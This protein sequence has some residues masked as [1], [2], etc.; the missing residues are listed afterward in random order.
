M[1]AA[2]S[3]ETTDRI[4]IDARMADGSVDVVNTGTIDGDVLLT[5]G[6]DR[7]NSD[8]GSQTSGV[9][10]GGHGNDTIAGGDSGER[11]FGGEGNDNLFTRA[12]DDT[13]EGGA[14]NDAIVLAEDDDSGSGGDGNDFVAGGPGSDTV[15]GGTGNDL[16]FGFDTPGNVANFFSGLADDNDLIVG[17]TGNDTLIGGPGADT[18]VFAP[19]DGIDLIRDFQIGQDLID[20]TAFSFT[21]FDAVAARG[22]PSGRAVVF[23]LDDAGTELTLVN[24]SLAALAEDS[25]LL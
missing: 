13:A 22:S 17:G 5:A 16:L 8:G 7:Y 19:G 23:D 4:A 21:G 6:D 10:H 24:V 11:F 14:G 15:E 9:V 12:G 2:A 25:F 1:S 20:L 3:S 18:F